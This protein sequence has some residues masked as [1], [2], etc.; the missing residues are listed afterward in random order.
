M[1]Q[2]IIG[3]V[4]FG[5]LMIAHP[6]KAAFGGFQVGGLFG[7]QLLQGKHW[8]DGNDTAALNNDQVHRLSTLSFLYGAHAKYLVELG[9]SKIVLGA[10][11]YIFIPQAN[12]TISLQLLNGPVEGNVQILHSRSLGFV[13]TGGMMLNPK[14]MIYLNAGVEIA[15]FQFI[16]NFPKPVATLS[17]ALVSLPPKQTFNH[18]FNTIVVGL[19]GSYKISPHLLIGVEVSSPF[20]KRF[21][22]SSSPIRAYNYKPVERRLILKISY[23]F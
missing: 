19:G 6:V 23:L 10:E 2:R 12:P 20:F 16:Y 7:I 18:N 8:Y 11:A 9:A 13:L 3:L 22:A 1:K 5:I 15:K 14:V 4:L 21:K 17:G